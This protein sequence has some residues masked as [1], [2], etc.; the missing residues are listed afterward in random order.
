MTM[1]QAEALQHAQ[2]AERGSL[3][4]LGAV[5]RELIGGDIS[6]DNLTITALTATTGAIATLTS[7]TLATLTSLIVT[8]AT[9][10]R[11]DI[12][13][14]QAAPQT[15]T[16]TATLTSAQMLGGILVATPTAAAAY[17]TLTGALLDAAVTMEAGDTFDLCIINLGGAGDIITLTEPAS[18]ITIVGSATVDDAGA[19]IN[20]SGIFRFRKT[21]ADT[22][23]AYRIA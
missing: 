8:G 18:G 23:I 21:A 4:S 6:L 10:L 11:G 3:R 9:Y 17:T 22:F 12:F 16:D 15:A 13:F 19:D 7:S 2:Q 5:L 14:N 1:T 20:S